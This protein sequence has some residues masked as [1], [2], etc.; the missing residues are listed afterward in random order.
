MQATASHTS[1]NKSVRCDLIRCGESLTMMQDGGV[2]T[3]CR[4]ERKE[5]CPNEEVVAI[6]RT[7]EQEHDKI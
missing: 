5:K 2:C 6:N 4:V 7:N 3:L 1:N